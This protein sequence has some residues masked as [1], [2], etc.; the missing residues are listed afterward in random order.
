MKVVLRKVRAEDVERQGCDE[1]LQGVHGILVPGGFGERG[2]EGKIR[3]IRFA[4]EHR[5]P[6]LGICLGMQCAVVEAA[7]RLAGLGDAHSTEFAAKTA[8]PVIALLEEQAKVRDKGGT[9]RLGAYPC[10]LAPGSLARAAYGADEV[11]ERHRHRYEFNDAYRGALAKVGL[12]VTGV[13][14]D[15]DLVEIVE[16]ENHPWF[17]GV[18]FHPEFRSRPLEPH[19]LFRDFVG[20][21]TA[22]RGSSTLF[23]A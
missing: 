15:G 22:R 12:K 21:A 23:P 14:P 6:F 3:A 4:A 20:A 13:C 11:R 9:M 8:H 5:I 18:Q 1:L 16:L 7:R 19:P 2:I 17:V 10:R